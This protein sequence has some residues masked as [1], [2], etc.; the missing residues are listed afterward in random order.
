MTVIKISKLISLLNVIKKLSNGELGGNLI[1]KYKSK[2]LV[3]VGVEWV[4]FFQAQLPKF[5]IEKNRNITSI[6]LIKDE[7][8]DIS[9]FCRN[10]ISGLLAVNGKTTPIESDFTYDILSW[11]DGDFKQL[12]KFSKRKKYNFFFNDN[13]V[14]SINLMQLHKKYKSLL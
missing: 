14:S 1:Y 7:I 6:E 8:D 12:N 3:E 10:K 13:E 9:K 11:I 5:I 2:S 4:D